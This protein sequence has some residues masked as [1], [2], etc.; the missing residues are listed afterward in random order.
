MPLETIQ[1]IET[2]GLRWINVSR[3]TSP[4]MEYLKRE[5]NFHQL[6]LDDCLSPYQRPKLDIRSDYLFL[7]LVFPIYRRKTREIISS[8]VDFFIG[9]NFLVTVHRNELPP[10]INLFNACQASKSKQDKYFTGNPSVLL[11][12][13]LN[14]LLISCKPILEFLNYF[15]DDIEES[16]F[17]GYERRMVRE[18]LIAKRDIIN[19]RRIMQIHRSILTKLI[20]KSE[21]FFSTGQLK[22]YFKELIETTGDIWEVLDNLNQS[23]NS[24]EATNNSLIS[25]RLNDIMKLLAIASVCF[26][27]VTIIA[28]LYN[29]RVPNLPLESNP[30]VFPSLLTIMAVS[31][32]ILFI[33]FKKKRWI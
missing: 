24:I 22:L 14:Q 25:F 28:S 5:F 2:R 21:Q 32:L 9:S 29:M 31:V 30:L 10:L 26:L 7:V 33:I 17:R 11:Y 23:I 19:F 3:V 15:I 16:I 8:E 27:P 18:I 13:L 6:H 1:T 20:E 12:E 4:E